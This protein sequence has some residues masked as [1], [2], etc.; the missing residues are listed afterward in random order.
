MSVHI[1]RRRLLDIFMTRLQLRR[2]MGS[3]RF[4][5]PSIISVYLLLGISPGYSQSP[6]TYSGYTGTDIK[7]Q[8]PAP[9][10]GPSNSIINDPVFGSRI[11][12][13]TDVNS[14]GGKSVMPGDGGFFRTFNANSTAIKLMTLDGF[15]YW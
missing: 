5:L 14:A 4:R 8:P 1:P 7:A 15:G 13:V 6:S 2:A 12:R 3:F 11:L 10:L 9:A